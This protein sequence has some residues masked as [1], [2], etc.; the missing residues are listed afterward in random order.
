[1][2]CERKCVVEQ[3]HQDRNNETQDVDCGER[4]NNKW[5]DY[6]IVQRTAEA[7]SLGPF[8]AMII[9]HDAMV[10]A[11]DRNVARSN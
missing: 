11:E 8:Q 4:D 10:S 2:H 6:H 9:G 7:A 1:L 5:D 3:P